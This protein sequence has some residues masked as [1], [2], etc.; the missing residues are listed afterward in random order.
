MVLEARQAL[1]QAVRWLD[2][3]SDAE[4]R[5][6]NA[7]R[8]P[9]QEGAEAAALRGEAEGRLSGPKPDH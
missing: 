3:P 7:E 1:G 9:W 8:L 6:S 2:A 5:Q 4:A